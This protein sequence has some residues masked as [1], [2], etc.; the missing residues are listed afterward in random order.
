MHRHYRRIHRAS[1]VGF[2]FARIGL[3]VICAGPAPAAMAAN[4]PGASASKQPNPAELNAGPANAD[5]TTLTSESLLDT[6]LMFGAGVGSG[7]L[8]ADSANVAIG[9]ALLGDDPSADQGGGNTPSPAALVQGAVAVPLGR[10]D[11]SCNALAESLGGSNSYWNAQAESSMSGQP[12]ASS[13]VNEAEPASGID[14]QLSASRPVSAWCQPRTE[15]FDESSPLANGS[16]WTPVIIVAF[17]FMVVLTTR[18]W[19]L[20][21]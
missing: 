9:T 4:L 10:G 11:E 2:R 3:V 1:N 16:F 8:A 18:G 7:D 13:V 19:R 15:P 17:G 21:P 5:T 12:A 6:A 14:S 20:P